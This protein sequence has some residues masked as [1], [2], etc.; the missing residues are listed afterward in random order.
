MHKIR[1]PATCA[2]LDTSK[3]INRCRTERSRRGGIIFL[4]MIPAAQLARRVNTHFENVDPLADCRSHASR[5]SYACRF[6]SDCKSL[7]V[8]KMVLPA[9]L[10]VRVQLKLCQSIMGLLARPTPYREVVRQPE[11]CFGAVDMI[12]REKEDNI[13]RITVERS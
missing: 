11:H 10:D 9:G 1:A 6:S 7:F 3:F 2:L 4:S 13:S 8:V 5:R 12:Y